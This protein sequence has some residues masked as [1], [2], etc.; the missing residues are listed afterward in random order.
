M[1]FVELL[2]FGFL[3]D[4]LICNAKQ[5]TRSSSN[6]ES[7]NL[8]VRALSPTSLLVTW[9][10]PSQGSQALVGYSLVFVPVNAHQKRRTHVELFMN[11]YVMANLRPATRYKIKLAPL[12]N[13]GKV[14][15]SYSNW[16][17]A[18]TPAENKTI[19]GAS[20]DPTAVLPSSS[21]V[22][23]HCS[24]ISKI[25][26]NIGYNFT[27]MPNYFCQQNHNDAE[28]ELSQFTS[29]IQSNCS[30]VLHVFLCALYF[31]PCV[32]DFDQP[33][34]PCRSVCRAARRDCEPWLKRFGFKWPY[35]FKCNGFPDPSDQACVGEDGTI[36]S[37]EE[38][39]EVPEQCEPL[40]NASM[41]HDLGY[42]LVRMPNFFRHKTQQ[43]AEPQIQ[44]FSPLVKLDCSPALQ[45]F[46]CVL[47]VPPCVINM[48]GKIPPCREVCEEAR[49]GCEPVMKNLAGYPWPEIMNC[50]RFPPF[51]KKGSQ[52]CLK[53]KTKCPKTTEIAR[54]Q[55]RC[56]PLRISM[57]KSLNYTHTI[58][59]N[60]LNHSS[61]SE[62]NR[63]LNSKAFKSQ[64]KSNCS[65]HLRRFVCFLFAPYCNSDGTPLPPC[66]TFCEKV[67]TDCADL[68]ARWL[69]D[70]NCARFPTLSRKRLCFGDPLTTMDCVGPHSRPCTVISSTF[71]IILKCSSPGIRF[72]IDGMTI[73]LNN[74]TSVRMTSTSDALRQCN[75]SRRQDEGR[76]E[77]RFTVSYGQ[78]KMLSVNSVS[79][80]YHC[81]KD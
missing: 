36:T 68:S 42:S 6:L 52:I 51:G 60:F 24:R 76:Y 13:N 10:T 11:R 55:S 35:K 58:L 49:R 26:E 12:M 23:G 72:A 71:P 44:I 56:Q 14:K 5:V 74:G 73:N 8:V 50:T 27:Q 59:P 17:N 2:W 69:A 77:C 79:V 4:V 9:D 29:M 18:W 67:K 57:C 62:V 66:K 30:P 39:I 38:P 70:L 16:V 22:P 53:P 7:L 28:Q 78:F 1:K 3:V 19:S 54:P 25:C 34:P 75:E 43:I 37:V 47:Y 21:Q 46:L 81:F 33:T 32:D 41:C 31:P 65:D 61:Q 48:N 80:K 45:F 40:N 64:L 15:G 63:I 20:S